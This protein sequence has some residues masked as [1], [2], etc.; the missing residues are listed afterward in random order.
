MGFENY[1]PVR[2][3]SVEDETFIEC[4]PSDAYDLE[5]WI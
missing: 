2:L 5:E 3:G 4:S 1:E